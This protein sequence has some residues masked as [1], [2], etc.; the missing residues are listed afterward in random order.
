MLIVET[1]SSDVVTERL[2]EQTEHSFLDMVEKEEKKTRVAV[3]N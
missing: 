3:L 2:S 1:R